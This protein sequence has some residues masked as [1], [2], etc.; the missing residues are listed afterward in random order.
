[1]GDPVADGLVASISRPGGNITGVSVDSGAGLYAKQLELLHELLPRILTVGYLASRPG[2]EA[3]VGGVH[4]AAQKLGISLVGP[5]L[6]GTI[7][8]AEIRRVFAAMVEA[9]VDAV[10]VND[11]PETNANARLIVELADKSRL[12]AMYT[13]KSFVVGGGLMAYGSDVDPLF[14]Q[15]ASAVDQI[16]KGTKPG[17][18]PI[19]QTTKLTLIINLKTAKALGIEI[20]TSIL[21]RADEVIE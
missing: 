1:M 13:Y 4:T 8:A 19:Y 16:L 18:I 3:W 5:P 10:L 12:P 17:E 11:Q 7:N 15:A 6:E 14:R 20:P 9:S 2:W 21:A